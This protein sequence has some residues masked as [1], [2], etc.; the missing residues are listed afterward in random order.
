MS[1]NLKVSVVI[2]SFNHREYIEKSVMSVLTQTYKNIELIVIDDGSTDGTDILLDKLSKKH[3]FTYIS[4][5]NEG[6]CKTLNRG[7]QEIST[8]DYICILGSDDYFHPEK[9]EKQL[10]ELAQNENSEFSYTQALEFDSKSSKELRRFPLRKF[11]GNI[12]NEI[13]YRQP[14]AAGSI[15][16]SRRLYNTVGGFDN[17]LKHED[18]DFSIRCSAITQFIGIN[19]PLFFYRSHDN[20]IMKTSSRHEIFL[21]KKK[22]LNKNSHLVSSRVWLT[23][24]IIHYLFDHFYWFLKFFNLKRLVN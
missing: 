12:L 7:I 23:S 6:V 5:E 13:F 17:N 22:V 9:V 21:T 3:N 19:E 16:F 14:Y 24:L 15:M 10:T 4:Q 8:G 2:P 1:L 18:W 11:S 20:N